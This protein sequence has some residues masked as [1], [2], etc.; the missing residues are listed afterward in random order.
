MFDPYK[1]SLAIKKEF[2]N[3]INT[4][5][6]FNDPRLENDFQRMIES[7][8]SK[9]P[10]LDIKP[11]F[12]S[13][14]TIRDLTSSELSPL[15]LELEKTKYQK[16]EN[17]LLT[18][19][20]KIGLPVDR[21]LY[22]HQ[23]NAIK[24][25]NEKRNLVV[26][27]GTG[28]GKTE[29]FLIPVINELLREKEEKG[30]ISNNVR[31][32]LI[33]PMNAL[34][35]DQM[36]RLRNILMFY[37][38]IK[39][40]SFTG[41]TLTF[42]NDALSAY[43]ELHSRDDYEE[44]K[45]G[46]P[47]EIKSRNEM[48]ANPPHILLTNYAMLERMLLVP[49]NDVL[50]SSSKMKFIVLDEAHV[51]SGA[52]GME[53]AMLL[54][55]LMAR[56]GNQ[57]PQFIL[58]SATL[59]KKGESEDD[60]CNF[61][62]NLTGGTFTEESIVYGERKKNIDKGL[63]ISYP[64]EFLIKLADN[65]E[66][67][68]YIFEDFGIE[69]DYLKEPKENIF[70]LCKDSSLYYN[71]VT[72]NR[73]YS[74]TDPDELLNLIGAS[75]EEE[76][77]AFIFLCTF[78]EKNGVQLLDA[79]Y[80][81][82]IRA[83]EGCYASFNK[84]FHISMER[85]KTDSDGWNYFEI[86]ICKKCGDLALYGVIEN[87]HLIQKSRFVLDGEPVKPRYFHFSKALTKL[88]TEDIDDDSI[89]E[90]DTI[91][92][93]DFIDKKKTHKIE[94]FYLCPK[95][96]EILPFEDGKPHCDCGIE[97]IVVYA[98]EEDYDGCL[99]CKNGYY[100]TF[101]LGNEGTTSVIA[102]SLFEQLQT[103]KI[104]VFEGGMD[105]YRDGG[106]QFLIFSDSRSEAAF[107]ASHL[108]QFY[109]VFIDRRSL[110]YATEINKEFI[111]KNPWSL[112]K[113]AG[114]ITKILDEKKTFRENMI[115]PE[116]ST[117][118]D[119]SVKHSWFSVMKELINSKSK[120]SL[121]GLGLVSF[122]YAGLDNLLNKIGPKIKA[123]FGLDVNDYSVRSSVNELIMTIAY[124]GAIKPTNYN[125]FTKADLIY[126]L[127]SSKW[128]YITLQKQYD[129]KDETAFTSRNVSSW[130]P[131]TK[132]SKPDEF[133]KSNRYFKVQR[134]LQTDDQSKIKSFLTIV[135]EALEKR[136]DPEYRLKSD[137]PNKYYLPTSAFIIR[138]PS[139][140]AIKW[141]RCSKCGN[142]SKYGVNGECIINGCDGKVESINVNDIN[143]ENHY[144]KALYSKDDFV[145]L[146]IKEHTAQLSSKEGAQIQKD[147]EKNRLNALS[148]STTFEMGVDLG[149]LET[150][151]L[152]DV[153]PNTSNYTQRSGRAGRSKDAAA[154]TV[155]YAKLSSHDFNYFNEPKLM[156]NGK[157]NP[158]KFKV[159][160]EKI[161]KRHIYA[162][163]LAYCF[164]TDSK[165]YDKFEYFFSDDGLK[166]IKEILSDKTCAAEIEKKI[167][168]SFKDIEDADFAYN[169]NWLDGFIGDS[170][171]LTLLIK[172]YGDTVK[173]YDDII[174]QAKNDLVNCSD[175][176][177]DK[178]EKILKTYRY[179]K[180]TFIQQNLIDALS[181]GNVI[182]KYGFPVDTVE[183]D[184]DD[185]NVNLSRDLAMAITEYSP[186]EKVIASGKEYTSRYIKKKR[187]T[188]DQSSFVPLFWSRCQYCGTYKYSSAPI[189]SSNPQK[190]SG[191]GADLPAIVW[192]QAIVPSEGFYYDKHVDINVPIFSKPLKVHTSEDCYVGD[193][194]IIKTTTYM[195]NKS[196]K[197]TLSH[198]EN[199]EIMVVS[200][201][202][203]F[204]CPTCGYAYSTSD[205]IK[206]ANNKT[207]KKAEA[208]LKF[209][210][211]FDQMITGDHV[212]QVG[213]TCKNHL[214]N[215]FNLAHVY[216]TDV[217]QINFENIDPEFEG[218]GGK[219][220]LIS[221]INALLDAIAAKFDIERSD[222]GGCITVK[223][224]HNELVLYD[225]VP[226]GAG[227]VKRLL[228]ETGF[229]LHDIFYRAYSKMEDCGC[230]SSCYK[231]LRAYH[232]Q[233]YHDILD[234]HDVM[235]FLIN[236]KDSYSCLSNGA[237]PKLSL[238]TLLS[239][240][241][242]NT[243]SFI[244]IIDDEKVFSAEYLKIYD[245]L[246]GQAQKIKIKDPDLSHSTIKLSGKNYEV[247]MTWKDRKVCIVSNSYLYDLLYDGCE[248]DVYML[249]EN[250]DYKKLI[251]KIK[252]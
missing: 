66:D 132:K 249:D 210:N 134:L 42:K 112:D 73:G 96:G 39:F 133:I 13:S 189:T 241:S 49:D 159:N 180:L 152:R 28:S 65:V 183:L 59:G 179:F 188:K 131:R 233:R 102:T 78:A 139:D 110:A 50:F 45:E 157:I 89:S 168:D 213:G 86:T 121:Q 98:A 119:L 194:H 90:T 170:G 236:Y 37:P 107:F 82:F 181:R 41:D 220:K 58:T 47:N 69:Y 231:C 60:I 174:E 81:F 15:F 216:K 211:N 122:E 148:C 212:N 99:I 46:L 146:F 156:I 7:M 201:N 106:K 3:Y 105:Q 204:V 184:V 175:S 97:P 117:M 40:G 235:N 103:K 113:M 44:L 124:W 116:T 70:N 61:A 195:F 137:E 186:G 5:F 38:D 221:L 1:S 52:R 252:E 150:V 138:H 71:L 243:D 237:K 154:Y 35:N 17:P 151:F 167:K 76:A 238:D 149:S 123:F 26:T 20:Y 104:K 25:C 140:P 160:N 209:G 182:P 222:I 248:Y 27:T 232:N 171:V 14:L 101:Y 185:K 251:S 217:V 64:P 91:S 109:E 83:L 163:A 48:L 187:I 176:D 74:I 250:L 190:C 135:F 93:E 108:N 199:D 223:N 118:H 240:A 206:D 173:Q 141:F 100:G 92:D 32:L 226:G 120:D 225:T 202:S 128:K 51:Y 158:P 30:F 57:N 63:N 85:K 68:E 127:Y 205:H 126:L 125:Q 193:G 77:V 114:E 129:E 11:T 56:I 87:D 10:Y 214:F 234:R 196:K 200:N 6:R 22:N 88:E 95:C 218:E 2:V 230:G 229:V 192:R 55:R 145:K 62:N 9:G 79:R 94:K 31:V 136:V 84:G 23:I 161:L 177:T 4:S 75:S 19:K 247:L 144:Y 143:A 18:K 54:R 198:S 53:T 162:I 12:E 8:I 244:N 43:K 172:E 169:F 245:T 130:L 72:N 111:L 115:A 242:K 166:R 142:I 191:C 203:Y 80:H 164:K 36:N 67:A 24:K 228:D 155:T 33:Y 227:H 239:K 153:P 246:I 178:Y 208:T 165:L 207:D 215:R 34:A 21:P 29:C 197:V 219:N 224:H 147:F 16:N